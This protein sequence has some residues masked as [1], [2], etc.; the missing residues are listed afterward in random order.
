MSFEYLPGEMEAWSE[1]FK[2]GAR[3][4][5]YFFRCSHGHVIESPIYLNQVQV[6]QRCAVCA[7]KK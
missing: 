4:A 3:H 7:E 1:F 5:K 6:D 2:S